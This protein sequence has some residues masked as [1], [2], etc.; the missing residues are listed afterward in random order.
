MPLFMGPSAFSQRKPPE[1][2]PVPVGPLVPSRFGRV[3][4]A[5]EFSVL[6]VLL[7]VGTY[8][9]RHIFGS[10]L[11]PAL[12]VLAAG[13]LLV[14]W[15]DPSFDRKRLTRSDRVSPGLKQVLLTFLPWAPVLA[16]AC[17][18]FRPDLLF[19]FPRDKTVTWLV[20]MLLYPLLSVYPQEII[21]RVFLFHRYR[22][23][24][25]G[26]R[27]KIAASGLCFGLAHLFFGNWIAPALSSI[28]GM[29]F[30]RTYARND[31]TIL[32]SL[33][34]ALWGDFIFTLGLGWY[35]YGGAIT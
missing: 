19:A 28:G 18:F 35:F 27:V 12:L 26:D 4:L 32:V 23:L 13:C 20:V 25:A 15:L 17:A 11:I 6:F 2:R 31:S 10:I 5:A 30:A 14:L 3:Y 29:L 16:L 1:G 34:H 21:F 9:F 8:F 22:A 24:F 33:E 7:P